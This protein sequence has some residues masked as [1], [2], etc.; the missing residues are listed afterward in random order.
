MR[1]LL[2]AALVLATLAVAPA[3]HAWT[4]PADGPVLRP[5][6]LSAD[7]YAGGQHRGIDIGANE[8]TAVRAPAS[9]VVSFVGSVPNGGRAVTIL[10]ADGYAVTL[11]QL[12]SASVTRDAVVDAGSLVGTVGRAP[13]ASRRSR[14][15]TSVSASPSSSTATSIR[16]RSCLRG[17]SPP[18]PPP[19]PVE[20]RAAAVAP[21][22]AA[23]P[24]APAGAEPQPAAAPLQPPTETDCG[25]GR[26]SGGRG[27]GAGRGHEARLHRPARASPSRVPRARRRLSPVDGCR[28][29]AARRARLEP[30]PSRGPRAIGS[31]SRTAADAPLQ[32][33]RRSPSRRPTAIVARRRGRVPVAAVTRPCSSSPT[34][35]LRSLR[36]SRDAERRETR[37]D[38]GIRRLHRADQG[39]VV[40]AADGGTAR[41][42][43]SCRGRSS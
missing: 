15:S 13:T 34:P 42:I 19:Q 21:A 28:R 37:W 43:A 20:A 29:R 36:R 18:P 30:G 14:T 27:A 40:V 39:L 6:S 41:L 32:R 31:A 1:R 12:G 7:P 24:A 22:E 23:A 2:S 16:S 8:G 35:L 33:P 5:F 3:A 10:T 9:G 26:P 17:A 38:G 11:L 4:W 25:R